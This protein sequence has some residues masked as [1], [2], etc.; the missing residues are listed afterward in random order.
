MYCT[1]GEK[2]VNYDMQLGHNHE[3][4]PRLTCRFWLDI[5][6]LGAGRILRLYS[7]L[8]PDYTQ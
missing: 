4:I 8:S 5:Y 3:N 6:V 7:K 1:T 2:E